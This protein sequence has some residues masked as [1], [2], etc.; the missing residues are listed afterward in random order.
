MIQVVKARYEELFNLVQ[1]EL[2]RSGFEEMIAAGIVLTG[3]ASKIQGCLELAEKIFQVPVRLGV[4]QNVRG[5]V[6]VRDNPA[7]STGVGLLLY[8]QLQQDGLS[9]GIDLDRN[10]AELWGK[11]KKWFQGHF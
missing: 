5:L 8:G 7:Y 9:A 3:G 4:P 6:D 1:A 11:M 10:E 2:H